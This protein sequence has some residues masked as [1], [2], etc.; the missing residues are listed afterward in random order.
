M[1]EARK[2]LAIWMT[3]LRMSGVLGP[4]LEHDQL[5]ADGAFRLKL[6]DGVDG[7]LLAQLVHDLLGHGLVGHDFD[8]DTGDG[9]VVGGAHRQGFDVVALPGEQPGDLGQDA[10]GVFHQ[11]REGAAGHGC[12]THFHALLINPE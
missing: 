9:G 11:H 6:L 7:E 1:M 4:D 8:G 3:S 5:P 10:G 2:M 12:F